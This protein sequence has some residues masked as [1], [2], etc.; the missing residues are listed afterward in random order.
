MDVVRATAAEMRQKALPLALQPRASDLILGI[1]WPRACAIN[2]K[3]LGS[4]HAGHV[5]TADISIAPQ[6][7]TNMPCHPS[8]KVSD[9]TEHCQTGAVG[10][11]RICKYAAAY[12]N[13]SQASHFLP[14]IQKCKGMS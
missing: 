11:S 7:Y 5:L 9:F 1:A 2:S 12:L 8:A 10:I 6:L 14:I 13:V 4:N 3:V